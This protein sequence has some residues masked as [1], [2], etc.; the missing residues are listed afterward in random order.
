MRGLGGLV[1]VL[2][3]TAQA[4]VRPSD[5]NRPV[6]EDGLGPGYGGNRTQWALELVGYFGSGTEASG[7][8]LDRINIAPTVR[9]ATPERRNDFEVVWA[10]LSQRQTFDDNGES[11]QTLQAGNVYLGYHWAWRTLERQIRLGVGATLPAASLPSDSAE[12][13]VEGI[14]AYTWSAAMRGWRE[15]WLWTPETF[16]ATGHFDL[17][18]RRASGVIV[19]G[20]L[21]TGWMQ[22]VT[23]SKAIAENELLVQADLEF[24]YDLAPVRLM[25]RGSLVALPITEQD[26]QLQSSVEPESRFR[27]GP[28]DLVARLTMPLHAPAGFAFSEGGAWAV[29]L[30]VANP[31]VQV[32]PEE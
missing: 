27:L 32:L 17:Y 6:G 28:M 12:E 8:A 18:L 3:A 21:T 22:R 19:G 16:T 1:L 23:D 25:L 11:R 31:T 30:G 4:E 5:I 15:L 2:A 26:D 10:L 9:I 7:R 20:A 29:H 14:D 24:I 13:I